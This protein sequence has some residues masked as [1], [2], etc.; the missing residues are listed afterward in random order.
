MG[1][2]RDGLLEIV[3]RWIWPFF[4]NLPGN[5]LE[6]LGDLGTVLL[7]AG[8]ALIQGFIDGIQSM[9]GAVGDALGKIPGAGA[10]GAIGGFASSVVPQMAGGGGGGGGGGPTGAYG[11]GLVWDPG[12]NAWVYPWEVGQFGTGPRAPFLGKDLVHDTAVRAWEAG[13]GPYP[14]Y[15]GGREAQTII[16]QVD[17]QELARVLAD[18]AGRAY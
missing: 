7:Q 10:V 5:I 2:L 14:T 8:K 9:G 17:G 3:D 16:L 4:R 1:G 15:T 6:L 11:S 13:E 18:H 12:A